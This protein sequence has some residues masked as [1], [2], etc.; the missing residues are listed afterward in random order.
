[1]PNL[2]ITNK[3]VIALRTAASKMFASDENYHDWLGTNFGKFS[4]LQLTVNEAGEAIRLISKNYFNQKNRHYG[5]GKP[6][7]Q[8]HLTQRQATK[9]G[10]LEKILGWENEPGRMTGFIQR[11][12]GRLKAVEMLMNWE[13]TKVIIGLQ[14]I[15]AGKNKRL[16]DYLNTLKIYNPE[17]IRGKAIIKS[18]KTKL[19]RKKRDRIIRDWKN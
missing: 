6:G 4:T 15:I 9:I 13:A 7:L 8:Q 12:T 5:T 1:M 16:Y 19:F 14:R 2:K 17:S 18:I 10:F 11:Q 3:Q